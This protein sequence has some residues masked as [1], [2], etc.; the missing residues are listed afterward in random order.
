MTSAEA[1]APH[2]LRM[3]GLAIASLTCALLGAIP[4]ALGALQAV[5]LS[6]GIV[7]ITAEDFGVSF[8]PGPYMQVFY[9]AFVVLLGFPTLAVI[10]GHL[11]RWR[12]R[13]AQG[14]LRG[15]RFA[16]AALVI[17]YVQLTLELPVVLMYALFF[18]AVS[19]SGL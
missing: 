13:P 15:K 19:Q 9:G 18:I 12:I 8:D 11:A 3:S 17:A 4:L 2:S 14:Q 5:L 16:T 6:H 1:V 7:L 10:V